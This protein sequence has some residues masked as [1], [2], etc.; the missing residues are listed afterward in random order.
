MIQDFLKLMI[1]D[2]T[3]PEPEQSADTEPKLNHKQ[4]TSLDTV[5]KEAQPENIISRFNINSNAGKDAFMAGLKRF[6]PNPR[7]LQERSSRFTSFRA[8]LT[9]DP[10]LSQQVTDFLITYQKS[11][12]TIETIL[13]PPSA[14]AAES[15]GQIIF[16]SQW[17]SPLNSVPFLITLLLFLKIYITPVMSFMLPFAMIVLP[18]FIMRFL[19]NTPITVDQYWEMFK[20]LVLGNIFTPSDNIGGT[21]H[22]VF[23]VGGF[24][25]SLG[26][27]MIQPYLTARHV[28]KI[29]SIYEEEMRTLRGALDKWLS[30]TSALRNKGFHIN[31]RSLR[32]WLRSVGNGHRELLAA[33]HDNKTL[34]KM[35]NR[36][37][38]DLEVLTAF[39]QAS[40]DKVCAAQTSAAGPYFA[41]KGAYDP[42]VSP[43]K[44]RLIDLTLGWQNGTKH[45]FLTGPNR[46]G[47]STALR[48]LL[49]NA[50]LAQT[51]GIGLAASVK[52]FPFSWIH[53]CLRLEDIPGS[54][55]FFEREVEMAAQSLRRGETQKPG[56]VLVDELFHSTNPPDSH[57]A[58][59][60][61]TS[62]IHTNPYILSVI[63][64]H[65]FSLVEQAPTIRRLCVPAEEKPDGSI[66]YK[67]G[68]VEGICRVSSVQDILREKGLVRGYKQ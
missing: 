65:D 26:Q 3:P 18:Y 29:D 55:S 5:I 44:R 53:S 31:D 9:D 22:K 64:T 12:A 13:K 1:E 30:L 34:I 57:R 14:E 32:F 56:L 35:W 21:I 40:P 33:L 8:L 23:Q 58:A 48:A 28:A 24:M 25:F 47:K 68:L 46:G 38:G 10:A 36:S 7:T 66:T 2:L 41:V 61:Y 43:E 45:T 17:F 19:F 59:C 4:A 60:L 54:T 67:Y 37:V 6:S 52:L 11:E 49:I 20:K 39:A 16:T 27:T 51:Y 15:I 50:L 42:Q 62:Q 63:S